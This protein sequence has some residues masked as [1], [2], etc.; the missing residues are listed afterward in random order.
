[1]QVRIKAITITIFWGGRGGERGTFGFDVDYSGSS[2]RY[3]WFRF[4]CEWWCSVIFFTRTTTTIPCRTVFN[5]TLPHSSNH[6][7]LVSLNP[8]NSTLIDHFRSITPITLCHT[9]FV[10]L[11]P[12]HTTL[13]IQLYLVHLTLPHPKCKNKQNI[14]TRTKIKTPSSTTSIRYSIT[15]ARFK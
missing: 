2:W 7:P 13:H 4:C 9:P 15:S 12:S 6:I 8:T 5:A 10:L 11:H 3:C 14:Q 1:M